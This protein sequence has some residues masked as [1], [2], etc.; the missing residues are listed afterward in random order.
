M[1]EQYSVDEPSAALEINEC[2]KALKTIR[3]KE[4]MTRLEYEIRDAEAKKDKE[5][6]TKDQEK[7]KDLSNKLIELTQ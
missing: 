5:Q 4:E 3:L 7:F 2:V 6:L 1:A